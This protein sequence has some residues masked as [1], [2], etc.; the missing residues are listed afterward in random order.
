VPACVV[1]NQ[2]KDN[3]LLEDYRALVYSRTPLGKAQKAISE[4]LAASQDAPWTI[5]VAVIRL[6]VTWLLQPLVTRNQLEPFP[7][8]KS[9][10]G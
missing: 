8:E 5:R 6:G 7:G 2:D 4:A 3:M 10:R 9:L 1:C